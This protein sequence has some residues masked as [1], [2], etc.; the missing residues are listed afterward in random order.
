MDSRKDNQFH[1][2]AKEVKKRVKAQRFSDR[3]QLHL[4]E[5]ARAETDLNRRAAVIPCS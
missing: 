2:K 4:K 1:G 3:L 5:P